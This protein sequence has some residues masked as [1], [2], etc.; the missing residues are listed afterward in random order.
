MEK[1]FYFV[2]DDTVFQKHR[3]D[4]GFR[5]CM[6]ITEKPENPR[7]CESLWKLMWVNNDNIGESN[8]RVSLTRMYCNFARPGWKYSTR[9][10]EPW[11]VD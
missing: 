10:G 2:D 3:A 7:V 11:R 6:K 4:S 1:I 5:V 8:R 9:V